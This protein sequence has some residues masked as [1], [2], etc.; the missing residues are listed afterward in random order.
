MKV[1]ATTS[2][3]TAATGYPV[4]QDGSAPATT[5][6]A[7]LTPSTDDTPGDIQQLCKPAPV[8]LDAEAARNLVDYSTYFASARANTAI[9]TKTLQMH[10]QLL[11]Q[12]GEL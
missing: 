9:L 1:N 4:P 5:T 2:T 12:L 10:D 8:S 6:R 7:D 3:T 11:K